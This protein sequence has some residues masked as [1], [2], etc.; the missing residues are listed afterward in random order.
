MNVKVIK[1]LSLLA[2]GAALLPGAQAAETCER[3]ENSGED[4]AASWADQGW[5][6]LLAG[7]VCLLHF[8]KDLGWEL[9]KRLLTKGESMKVTLL[10]DQASLPVKGTPG[11]AGWDLASS[12]QVTLQ[13]GERRL[14]PLGLLL[15]VPPGCYG[16]IAPRSSMAVR[17][18]DMAGGVVDADFRGEVKI[19]L[20]NNGLEPLTV[21]VGDRIGQL[22]LEKI[23]HVK[24][25]KSSILSVTE[26][27]SAGFGSAGVGGPSSSTSREEAQVSSHGEGPS[28]RRTSVEPEGHTNRDQL[29]RDL[30]SVGPHVFFDWV[31]FARQDETLPRFIRRLRESELANFQW[32]FPDSLIDC[33]E[34]PG[35]K[36]PTT[37][38]VEVLQGTLNILVYHHS[39]WRKKLYDT[40]VGAPPS[41]DGITAGVVT[42]GKLDDGRV[43]A[44]VDN[45]RGNRS[46]GYLRQSWCGVSVFYSMA[47]TRVLSC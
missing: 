20:V 37:L 33:L 36:C 32:M 31:L 15:E 22:I 9:F 27:G 44:R 11:A 40:E 18:V 23:A 45:R 25:E 13:P 30:Q 2:A 3:R 10:N 7:L 39:D 26:R 16:R 1:A 42:L 29:R 19:I 38:N 12:V 46:M 24:V 6:V 8:L 4:N 41:S 5:I 28:V 14:V 21:S 34:W 35:R 43:F 17:G 47:G